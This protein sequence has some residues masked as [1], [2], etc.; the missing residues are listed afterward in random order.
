M[1]RGYVLLRAFLARTLGP[2][3]GLVFAAGAAGAGIAA[4]LIG[5]RFL[6]APETG[7]PDLL[8]TVFRN[9]PHAAR[10]VIGFG[11]AFRLA[12]DAAADTRSGWTHQLLAAG[13]ERDRYLASLTI[14]NALGAA[15]F[16]LVT[17]FAWA[18]GLALLGH[19]TAP[20]LLS[21]RLLPVGLL[22]LGAAVTFGAAALAMTAHGSGAQGLMAVVLALPWVV[23]L[24]LG[25]RLED[26]P[27]IWLAALFRLSPPAR[28]EPSLHSVSG[29]VLFTGVAALF[30][31]LL[32]HRL[33][34]VRT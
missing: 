29:I 30:A 14:A 11:F 7:R 10:F 19:G 22:W 3:G 15:S 21:L 13:A 26:S 8:G 16:L 18:F 1:I 32:C 9:Y 27:P 33:L 24:G 17:T 12:A 25:Q 2:A 4:A 6:I 28:V 23:V 34:R 20:V 31:W 5:H